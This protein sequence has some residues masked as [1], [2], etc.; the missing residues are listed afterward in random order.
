[1][2][3]TIHYGLTSRTCSAK[4]AK[5]LVEQMRQLALDLSNTPKVRSLFNIFV[6]D[7]ERLRLA[8]CQAIYAMLEDDYEDRTSDEQLLDFAQAN[9]YTF[10][11]NGNREGYPLPLIAWLVGV[12]VMAVVIEAGRELASPLMA[13]V[14]TGP[15]DGHVL[16][17]LSHRQ[18]TTVLRIRRLLTEKMDEVGEELFLALDNLN[19]VQRLDSVRKERHELVQVHACRKAGP[20]AL[21]PEAGEGDLGVLESDLV[22]RI[23]PEVHDV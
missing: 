11:A 7:A 12:Q 17:M 23:L 21:A 20:V 9:D 13:V 3:L 6:E 14:V 4:K 10:E 15:L 2:G 5:E 19:P 18:Q 8:L 16:N 22:Q 1:M